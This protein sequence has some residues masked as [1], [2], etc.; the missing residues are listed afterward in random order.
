MIKDGDVVPFVRPFGAIPI[1]ID[2]W[3]DEVTYVAP[4]RTFRDG[5]FVVPPEWS[6]GFLVGS[7]PAWNALIAYNVAAAYMPEGLPCPVSF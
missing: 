6:A 4:M 3:V 7:L 5:M 2:R 1:Y